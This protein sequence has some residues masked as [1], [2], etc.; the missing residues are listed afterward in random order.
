MQFPHIHF[1]CVD[2]KTYLYITEEKKQTN[3][4]KKP[5]KRRLT[6]LGVFSKTCKQL[7]SP[8]VSSL[9]PSLVPGP[10]WA[11]SWQDMEGHMWVGLVYMAQFLVLSHP[12]QQMHE[13]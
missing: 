9:S 10:R 12:P 13:L 1:F 3:K 4:N 5:G 11:L 8:F 6:T 2:F 7:G